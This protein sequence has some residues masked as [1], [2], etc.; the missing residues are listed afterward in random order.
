MNIKQQQQINKQDNYKLGQTKPK[1]TTQHTK[2]KNVTH[3]AAPA[4]W[5]ASAPIP[6]F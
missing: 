5:N 6:V 2:T 3:I 4:T 1:Q